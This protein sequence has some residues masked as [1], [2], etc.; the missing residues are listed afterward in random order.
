MTAI[1][2]AVATPVGFGQR[3]QAFSRDIRRVARRLLVTTCILP[4]LFP[5]RAESQ[6]TYSNTMFVH[7]FASDGSIWSKY[8]SALQTT[9]EAYLARSVATRTLFAPSLPL[10]RDYNGQLDSLE[11]I[12]SS[13]TTGQSVL[14][15]HSLGSLEARGAYVL[16]GDAAHIA[17]II[18]LAPPHQGTYLA[19]NAV[20]AQH[21]FT[22]V[23]SRVNDG[24]DGARG[25]ASFLLDLLA[26]AV[27]HITPGVAAP[28]YA[29]IAAFVAGI[30]QT[31]DL[32]L[33]QLYA[34]LGTPTVADLKTTSP[35]IQA[36][37]QQMQDAAI[38]RANIIATMPSFRNAVLYVKA[39]QS[40][41]DP[42]ALIKQLDE[43]IKHFR[44]CRFVGYMLIVTSSN[45]RK[46]ANAANALAGIDDKWLGFVNGYD[47]N[48]RPRAVPFDGVVSNDHSVYPSPN[49]IT[50]DTQVLGPNHESIY[51]VR[52]GLD[53]TT[54]GMI[55]VGMQR[56]GM[57]SSGISGPSTLP[58]FHS[59]TW[60]IAVYGATPP[61]TYQWSGVLTGTGATVSGA[62]EQSG[63]LIVDVWD[64]SGQ[65]LRNSLYYTVAA[66]CSMGYA[67]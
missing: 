10:S 57:T 31:P 24:V 56:A 61:Y 33:S 12:L 47:N 17:A 13:R 65:H 41:A 22:D 66:S 2:T 34:L 53:A 63:N 37:N 16:R 25:I 39:A 42:N 67:C 21:Y 19:D 9:P 8:Y 29:G 64:Q 45:A 60:S 48:G 5:S 55:R 6:L 14:V 23:Q 49:L 32:G 52:D 27:F 51:N 59:S 26:N 1:S 20:V 30:I 54:L 50:F 36:L 40:Q 38:P 35:T 15:G 18:A 7:G 43:G 11:L 58:E 44:T 46:C 3:M 28:V 4:C 62:P